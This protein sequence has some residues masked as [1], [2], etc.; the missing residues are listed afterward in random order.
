MKFLCVFVIFLA[1]VALINALPHRDEY[2]NRQQAPVVIV[3]QPVIIVKQ[4]I[5]PRPAPKIIVI[6]QRPQNNRH[7]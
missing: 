3:K 2:S 6:N 4:P 1:F 7:F 5:N